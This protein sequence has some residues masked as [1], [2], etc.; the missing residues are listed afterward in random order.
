MSAKCTDYV[1]NVYVWVNKAL[2]GYLL[3]KC[4]GTGCK[5]G[6]VLTCIYVYMYG[7]I[8]SSLVYGQGFSVGLF[9]NSIK[10]RVGEKV[11]MGKLN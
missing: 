6:L 9:M 1:L 8:Y 7:L 2:C 11:V 4:K 3:I 5:K 10:V